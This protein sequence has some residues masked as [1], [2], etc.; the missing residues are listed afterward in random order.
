M[1]FRKFL[2]NNIILLDGGTGSLLIKNGLKA[3]EYPERLNVS[4]SDIITKI[5][6]DYYDAG[7]NVVCT[8]TFGAN[9]LKFSNLELE[10][11]IK[12]AI[13][14]V[15]NAQKLS[16][17]KQKKFVAL[18][19]GPT[20][21]MLKPFGDL[22]FEDA[23]E[24][25][26]TTVKIAVKYGVDLVLIETMNDIYETKAAVLAVKECST[27]PI[28]VSNVYSK[29]GVTLSGTTPESA[30]ATLEGLG[31]DAIG[32]NCSLGPKDLIPV[33]EKYLKNSSIPVL[34]KPNAGLPRV[35]GDVTV[36]DVDKEIFATD[37]SSMLDK[38]VRIVGGCCGTTPEYILQLNKI[39][40]GKKPKNIV[41]KNHTV[42]SSFSKAVYFDKPIIIGER[43][44]PTGKKRLKQAILDDDIG[45]VLEEAINQQKAGAHVLDVNVGIP[46]KDEKVTL[47]KFIKEIQSAIDLPLQI[48]TVSF[49]ALEKSLRIYNGK[50]LINS[51]NGKKESM[52]T[53]FPLAKKYGGAIVCLCLD[54]SGIPETVDGRIT[55][56]KKIINK[57]KEYGIKEKDLIFDALTMTISNN[58]ENGKITLET[59]ERIS[60]MGYKTILGVSNIS[61]GLPNRD[62]INSTFLISALN[63]GLSSAI[64]NPLSQEMMKA[65]Y[66]YSACFGFD[67]NFE[68]YI[69]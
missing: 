11:I 63:K 15:K 47:V 17:G 24:I 2:K 5:H 54:E 52:E 37:V 40:K 20:G 45:Y 8:N 59:I 43:I 53:V 46:E 49:N 60:K 31:V 12:C 48:D 62:F 56:A 32:I 23:V 65:F 29:D 22:D 4:N 36:Y 1:D 35:D 34:F 61:F 10:K 30:I 9:S 6:K 19:I 64:M 39:I 57:A 55:I 67:K 21:K 16:K 68:K 3:N 18:D 42:V 27:L 69:S 51:V 13:E 33:I 66:S 25:F 38:G 41:E 44:N 58:A 50:P 14:N 28:L 26:K 7:S